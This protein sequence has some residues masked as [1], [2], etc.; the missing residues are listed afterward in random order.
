M[1]PAPL[2]TR[3]TSVAAGL[4]AVVTVTTACGGS[5]SDADNVKSTVASFF[6]A[7]GDNKADAACALLTDN[8][9]KELSTAAFLLRP[10]SSCVDAI[11]TFNKVLTSDDK[12]S[13]KTTKVKRVTITGTTATVADNDIELK[14]GGEVGLFR[15]SSPKPLT[16]EKI[17]SD[18][19]ISSLG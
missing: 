6:G 4:L 16:L 15:N 5:K 2:R 17:G 19:K 10:P 3:L 13:L 7:V 11:K 8:G 1:K 12:K 9:V 14:A 18:W